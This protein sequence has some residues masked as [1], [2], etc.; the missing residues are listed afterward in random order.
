MN[1]TILKFLLAL[2]VVVS[3]NVQ[4]QTVLRIGNV[5]E[6]KTLDPHFV[7]GVWENR[8]VGD[9]FM[10]LTTE[11]PDASTIPGAA[12]SWTVSDDGL[13][14]TFK[15]RAHNWSD[16]TPVS[17]EDFVYSM[18][19]ILLPATAAEYA[20]LLYTI[21]NAEAVNSGKAAPEELAV[22]AL[23]EQTLEITLEAPAPFFI[24]Q[25]THYT[26][27]PVPRHVVEK[28][29][30]DWVKK[31]NI[32]SN[33][34]YV[35]NEWIPNTHVILDKNPEFY[36]AANVMIDQVYFDPNE[37][38]SAVQKS[39]R[40]G[41]LDI[42]KDFASDQIDWL[43]ENLPQET[44]IAPYLGIYYYPINTSKAPFNDKRVR[45][46]LSMAL[47]REA[48]TDKVL[49]TGEVPAYSFVPPGTGNYAAGPSY[50]SW[51][52]VPYAERVEQAKA[53][54]AEAGFGPDNPL[55]F[56]L[57]YN[58]SENHKR[59]AIAASAMWKQIGVQAELFNSE[60]KVH[61]DRLKQAD[62]D[63]ARAGWIA[64]Y[65]DPQNFLYL[66]ETR[67][68]PNNYGRFDNAEYNQLMEQAQVTSDLAKRAEI[69]AKA[70]AIA[71]EEQ[72]IIPIYYYVSK[73]LVSQAVKGWIDNTK[74]VQRT[75]WLSKDS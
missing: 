16:G 73:N 5:G 39:F 17:A 32:V 45:Q 50:V 37:D 66:L 60:V 22:K 62:F 40:A 74:D 55:Q 64:D 54:L 61:Y 46:A 71:M 49:K 10:G 41:E 67:T 8:I 69:M 20:S 51:K 57:S 58:T 4:A 72:P 52:D 23:D 36:D 21:K 11:G 63:I 15:L 33:G 75:R 42:A 13:V 9:L 44:H 43:R 35:L 2:A 26:A 34:P 27:F 14:Y 6:P 24:D 65:N 38:R 28:Y 30:N 1:T 12:E 3:V 7:S 68:G 53:L 48:I 25:L 18:R 31:G 56:T 47:N 19:R 59:I 70:E 29:G